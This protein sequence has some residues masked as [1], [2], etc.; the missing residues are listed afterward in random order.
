MTAFEPGA[1]APAAGETFGVVQANR[2]RSPLLDSWQ[3]P[4]LIGAAVAL[5]ALDLVVL[6]PRGMRGAAIV[7]VAWSAVGLGFAASSPWL[8]APPPAASTWPGT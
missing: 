1:P 2:R 7:T 3:S 8:R 5:L 4:V 6:R